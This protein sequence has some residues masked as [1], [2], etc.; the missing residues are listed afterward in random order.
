M[1]VSGNPKSKRHLHELVAFAVAHPNA[2][3]LRA[4]QPAIGDVPRSGI[5]DVEG[6]HNK[7]HSWYAQVRLEEGIIVEVVA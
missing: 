1:Y 7:M 6:P 3:Q 5:V 4:F 2:R